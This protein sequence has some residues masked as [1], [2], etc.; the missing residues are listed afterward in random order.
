VDAGTILEG[1]RLPGGINYFDYQVPGSDRRYRVIGFSRTTV[2][3]TDSFLQVSLLGRRQL[4]HG[5]LTTAAGDLSPLTLAAAD[6]V[7]LKSLEVR[8][9]FVTGAWDAGGR[10]YYSSNAVS[11]RFAR[12]ARGWE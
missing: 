7:G 8:I 12:T 6:S 4:E 11:Y 1:G 9:V 3:E 10:D 5:F 2:N